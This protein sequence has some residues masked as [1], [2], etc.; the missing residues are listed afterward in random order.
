[1]NLNYIVAATDSSEA[2]RHAVAV[3]RALA[4][5]TGARISVMTAV[6]KGRGAAV[7]AGRG[8]PVDDGAEVIVGLPGIEIP[9]FAEETG[10]DLLVLGRK[11]RSQAERLLLGDTADSVARRSRVPCLFVPDGASRFER[12]LAALDGSR[13]G[14]AVLDAACGFSLAV[15]GEL[16]AVTVERE[17][18]GEEVPGG[19]QPLTGRTVQLDD[20]V[21]AA[22]R[23]CGLK[24]IPLRVRRGDP[25][26]GVLREAVAGAA[27]VLVA[28][29][30]RGG[31]SGVIDAG[32]TA[33][34]LAHSA[35]CLFLTIP[36]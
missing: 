15:G 8:A 9:R 24:E 20:E 11:T 13:R 23:R 36:L 12:V 26:A 16:A 33:R 21:R 14:A 10:A 35:P 22:E 32:S 31:P 25:V 19:L 1:M 29:F 27:D 28:G 17:Y 7:A 4:D 5:R 6:P 2:S 18:P 3:A 34:R 30:H